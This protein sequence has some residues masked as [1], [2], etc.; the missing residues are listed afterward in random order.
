MQY[1]AHIKHLHPDASKHCVRGAA[2]AL[3]M[4][5]LRGHIGTHVNAVPSYH[6]EYSSSYSLFACHMMLARFI[7]TLLK[8]SNISKPLCSSLTLATQC[9]HSPSR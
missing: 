7:L 2:G 8:L 6:D 3:F 4:W 5:P 1:N 9:L